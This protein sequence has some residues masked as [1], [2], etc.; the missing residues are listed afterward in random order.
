MAAP[1]SLP[2]LAPSRNGVPG[3]SYLQANLVPFST[4]CGAANTRPPHQPASPTL[5]PAPRTTATPSGPVGTANVESFVFA[6]TVMPRPEP[7]RSLMRRR[8]RPLVGVV[9]VGGSMNPE[10]FRYVVPFQPSRRPLHAG[11]ITPG[12]TGAP[13]CAVKASSG[14][15]PLATSATRSWAPVARG[16]NGTGAPRS[17]GSVPFTVS[18]CRPGVVAL[19]M[20][21]RAR[22]IGTPV[23]HSAKGKVVVV[24]VVGT[25]LVD[26]LTE[27][28][29]VD[30]LDVLVEVVDELEVLV[31]LVEV[32]V[33]VEL[34]VVVVVATAVTLS[35]TSLP[36]PPA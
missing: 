9:H 20:V 16:L 31:V 34:D 1:A 7:R 5:C 27:V 32:V 2:D 23:R 24:V 36:V 14:T 15:T 13:A 17:N 12:G 21:T 3:R 26:V 30:E 10:A 28:E 19:A 11:A 22:L 35:S 29:V 8:T 25:V 4:H 18:F 6:W 33:E